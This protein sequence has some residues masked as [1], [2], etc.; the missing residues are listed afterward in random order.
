MSFKSFRSV[1]ATSMPS[2]LM[3]NGLFSLFYFLVSIFFTNLYNILSLGKTHVVEANMSVFSPTNILITGLA[4][5]S[6]A[7][8]TM[9]GVVVT[10]KIIVYDFYRDDFIPLLN[11]TR[12][13]V[14]KVNTIITWRN[15]PLLFLVYLFPQPGL[16]PEKIF[17]FK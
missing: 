7:Y 9:V 14:K 17:T 3:A 13:S 16:G 8:I 1:I 12:E 4:G 5:L 6:V 15:F 10:V 11:I 2:L